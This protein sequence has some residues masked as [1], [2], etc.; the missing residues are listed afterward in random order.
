MHCSG[1]KAIGAKLGD[2]VDPRMRR[3]EQERPPDGG[4]ISRFFRAMTSLIRVKSASS[5]D[6]SST[7]R[8]CRQRGHETSG[9]SCPSCA[10]TDFNKQP[11]QNACPQTVRTGCQNGSQQIGQVNSASAGSFACWR[12][13]FNSSSGASKRKMLSAGRSGALK[14]PFPPSLRPFLRKA[15]NMG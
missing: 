8:A 14:R 11:S 2:R 15:V 5:A 10:K 9:D 4:S 13:F 7:W 12:S 3:P 6:T 1:R